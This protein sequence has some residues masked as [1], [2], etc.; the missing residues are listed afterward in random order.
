M[1]LKILADLAQGT[2]EWRAAR[3]GMVTASVVGQLLTPTRRIADN[4][5]S[6]GCTYTLAAERITG[7]PELGYY[8][9]ADMWRGVEDEPRAR[10]CY[11]E[12]H[13]PVEEVG[14]MIRDDW[15]FPIG[16][17]PDGLVGDAGQIE[18][19]SC[20]PK[21]HLKAILEDRVPAD[22]M[23][24]LQCGLLV[25]GRAWV[26]YVSF[27]GGMPLWV[28]RVTPDP[29]WHAAIVAAIEAFEENV[30]LA[31]ASY[32]TATVGLP[33]TERAPEYAEMEL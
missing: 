21:I 14:F 22:V 4:D 15:G 19:K 10:D 29:D 32:R 1:T 6:R 2:D 3:C 16:Y 17:S 24:Q 11:A 9:G 26:D 33:L 25:S 5:T 13:A 18:I 30:S 12:H 23:P 31:I 8:M 20:L 28:K 7:Y 27:C